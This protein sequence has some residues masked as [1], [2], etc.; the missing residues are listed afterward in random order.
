MANPILQKLTQGLS[1]Q[2]NG[3]GGFINMAKMIKNA[4]NPEAMFNE[5]VK[6]NP[7]INN[8]MSVVK[9]YGNN[10]KEAYYNLAKQMGVDPDE[11][12]KQFQ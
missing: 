7:N 9:K 4:N 6:Q 3:L 11:F 8:V 5:I 1:K 2:N 10:P 12:L